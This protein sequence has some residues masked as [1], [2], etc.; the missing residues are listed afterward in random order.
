MRCPFF[1]SLEDRFRAQAIPGEPGTCWEWPHIRDDF[2]Y[3]RVYFVKNK[4]QITERTHRVSYRL[5][6]G[7]IT[8]GMY[9][10]HTCD[11]PA[12][13]NPEHLYLGTYKDNS[14][15][16]VL[17]GRCCTALTMEQV[18][19][20]ITRTRTGETNIGSKIG[21]NCK[22]VSAI[23]RKARWKQVWQEMFPEDGV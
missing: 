23:K 15:D 1:P 4:K 3:G 22:I 8:P 9:V 16:Q 19:E 11:N 5:N 7:P 12:C 21:V 13:W 17:R 14:R 2:G 18:R 20:I 6:K 10:L